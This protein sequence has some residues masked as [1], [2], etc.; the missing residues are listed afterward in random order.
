MQSM[1]KGYEIKSTKQQLKPK[2]K[3]AYYVMVK[4]KNSPTARKFW[5]KNGTPK[6]MEAYLKNHL[7]LWENAHLAHTASGM[8]CHYYHPSSYR[9]AG[10][11]HRLTKERYNKCCGHQVYLLSIIPT[12]AYKRKTRNYSCR[13]GRVFSLDDV[14]NY[15]NKNI[16]RIDIRQGKQLVGHYDENGFR[17][18]N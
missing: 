3:E 7:H 8:I 12:T 16:L 2:K 1:N 4:F 13:S 6:T 11:Q 14:P 17:E 18:V 9:M 15:W 10:D 5:V